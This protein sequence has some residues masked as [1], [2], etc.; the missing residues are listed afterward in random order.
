MKLYRYM[1]INEFNKMLAGI[2]IIG[3]T[4]LNARTVSVGVCFLGENT[5]GFMPEE[6][7]EF[8]SGIVDNDV[9]VEFSVQNAEN[10]TESFGIYAKPFCDYDETILVTEYCISKYNRDTFIPTRYAIV[11]CWNH[12]KW[13]SIN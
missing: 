4:H 12:A 11:E 5:E 8:L 1:S 2:D 3:K 13:Y 6:C 9:L 10:I 7:I